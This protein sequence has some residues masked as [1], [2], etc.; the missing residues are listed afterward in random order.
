MVDNGDKIAIKFIL[1][2]KQLENYTK[3]IVKEYKVGSK[4]SY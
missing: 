3:T 4:N 1:H 2:K